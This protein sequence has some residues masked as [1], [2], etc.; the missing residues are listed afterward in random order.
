MNRKER[1][2]IERISGEKQ[3]PSSLPIDLG[4]RAYKKLYSDYKRVQ[5][6]KKE[7]WK[8]HYELKG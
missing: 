6:Y 3:G 5:Y 8:A 4:I 7:M 1:R 2:R